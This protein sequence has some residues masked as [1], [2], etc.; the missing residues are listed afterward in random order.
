L[1]TAWLKAKEPYDLEHV[2]SYIYHHPE[3]FK[4]FNV[5][6]DKDESNIRLTVD[7]QEDY[8]R[9]KAIYENESRDF[10]RWDEKGNINP[11]SPVGYTGTTQ[12][13]CQS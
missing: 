2:T 8:E 7:T 1:R 6:N 9:V 4:L 11:G 12:K 10:T 5:A 3:M 13:D